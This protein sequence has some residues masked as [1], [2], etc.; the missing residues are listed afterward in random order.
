M[1]QINNVFQIAFLGDTVLNGDYQQCYKEGEK[2]FARVKEVLASD[3]IVGNLECFVKGDNGENERKK[4]RLET[5]LDTINYLKDIGLNVACLANNHV[6]DHLDDGFLKTITW[7]KNNGIASMGASLDHQRAFQPLILSKGGIQ[8]GLLNYVTRDTNPCQPE[9]TKIQLNYFEEEDVVQAIKELKQQVDH[10]VLSLHWGGRLEG[11]LYP[12]WHQPTQARR[13]IDAGA[14]VIVGHHS[15]TVQPYE[16][17]KGKYI[18]YSIGNFCFSNFWSDGKPYFIN[19]RGRVSLVPVISFR[20]RDYLVETRSFYNK[21]GTLNPYK[22]KNK[23]VVFTLIKRYKFVWGFYYWWYRRVRPI[24]RV[25][26]NSEIPMKQKIN[27]ISFKKL[28][29][30]FRKK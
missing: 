14:D 17:Y 19:E 22:I 5:D 3:K 29:K 20:K 26:L 13:L 8:V 11:G 16:V 6:F 18:F 15:H 24:V 9:Q 23:R 10:V 25:M 1:S 21:N 7:L 30:H 2:P 12:D 4:P 28:V 27:A